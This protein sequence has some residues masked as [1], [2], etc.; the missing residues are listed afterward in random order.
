MDADGPAA[1]AD[2]ERIVRP[3]RQPRHHPMP[4]FRVLALVGE[5]WHLKLSD[6]VGCAGD[7]GEVMWGSG[8]DSDTGTVDDAGTQWYRQAEGEGDERSV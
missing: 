8:E 2:D 3:D 6:A 1:E 4:M 7:E 5:R